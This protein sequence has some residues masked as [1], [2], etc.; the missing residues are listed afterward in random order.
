MTSEPKD[1]TITFII[2]S[3]STTYIEMYVIHRI[4]LE[5]VPWLH[6]CTHI[7]IKKYYK[8]V[9]NLHC[10]KLLRINLDTVRKKYSTINI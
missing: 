7:P 9:I 10:D 1:S 8:F 6:I 5:L 3:N 4:W 2:N